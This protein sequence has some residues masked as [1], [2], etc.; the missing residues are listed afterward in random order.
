MNNVVNKFKQKRIVKAQLG[1]GLGG[2]LFI[3][4]DWAIPQ[5]KIG[6]KIVSRNLVVRFKQKYF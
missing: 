6:G 4:E 5:R 1:T 2:I 3:N